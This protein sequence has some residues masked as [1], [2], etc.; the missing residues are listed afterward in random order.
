MGSVENSFESPE[1][2]PDVKVKDR[3]RFTAEGDPIGSTSGENE[4]SE[5]STADVETSPEE[6]TPNV[7]DVDEGVAGD[8]Q[9][10]ADDPGNTEPLSAG[11]VPPASFEMLILSLGMQAQME[12][13]TGATQ[14]DHPP[15]LEVARH[16]VDLLGVLQEKT[17]GNL[18]LQEQRLLENTVTE[19][20]FRYVQAVGDITKNADGS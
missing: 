15:N 12:L 18:S 5:D 3:R 19:L 17:K 14:S 9:S 2:T 20:R 4:T 7:N 6:P 16:T 1:E 13:G 10:L 11:S 8:N